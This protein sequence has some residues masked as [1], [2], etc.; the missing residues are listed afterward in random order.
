MFRKIV[1]VD[2]PYAGRFQGDI[3]DFIV[4]RLIVGPA[5]QLYGSA[6]EITFMCEIC[7]A[8]PL[9]AFMSA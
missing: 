6:T 3:V 1:D 8:R 7:E 9:S 4:G 5:L 2:Q